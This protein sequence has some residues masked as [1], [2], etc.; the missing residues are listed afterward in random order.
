MQTLSPGDP[1]H[2]NPPRAREA[3]NHVEH[4]AEGDTDRDPATDNLA[5]A[6]ARS[7]DAALRSK[8]PLPAVEGVSP[9]SPWPRVITSGALRLRHVGEGS[10]PLRTRPHPPRRVPS[11]DLKPGTR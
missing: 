2:R 8:A 10:R 4:P 5:L 11:C 3:S 7:T 6:K 9:Q 1:R